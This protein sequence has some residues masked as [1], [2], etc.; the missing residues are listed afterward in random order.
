M[1]DLSQHQD[2]A[3]HSHGIFLDWNYDQGFVVQVSCMNI[4][5]G[6]AKYLD[7]Q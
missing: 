1:C 6:H 2:S 3:L 5:K 7:I 4:E